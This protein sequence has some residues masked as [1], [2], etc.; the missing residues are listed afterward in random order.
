MSGAQAGG[1]DA[2]HIRIAAAAALLVNVAMAFLASIAIVLTAPKSSD[3]GV[4]A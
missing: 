2:L 4:L 1:F 3:T